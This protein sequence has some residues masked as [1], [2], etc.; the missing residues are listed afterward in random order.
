MPD[1]SGVMINFRAGIDAGVLRPIKRLLKSR[2]IVHPKI[3]LVDFARNSKSGGG[4]RQGS[5]SVTACQ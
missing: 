2:W 3:I 4:D 1:L 5:W